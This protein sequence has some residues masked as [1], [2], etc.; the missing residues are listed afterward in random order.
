MS[1]GWALGPSTLLVAVGAESVAETSSTVADALGPEESVA[2]SV[3]AGASVAALSVAIAL[4]V[5]VAVEL[6]TES[7]TEVSETVELSTLPSLEGRISVLV[8]SG[9]QEQVETS[10]VAPGGQV[11]SIKP[12][13]HRN[14]S[15]SG[16]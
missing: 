9:T 3:G 16:R 6:S 2:E 8:V 15:A 13:S 11:P 1:V 7:V 12:I 4:S 14:K 5:A 10:G